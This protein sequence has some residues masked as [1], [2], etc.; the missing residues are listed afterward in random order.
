[1]QQLEALWKGA[2]KLLEVEM[3]EKCGGLETAT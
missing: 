2:E 3:A 1:L